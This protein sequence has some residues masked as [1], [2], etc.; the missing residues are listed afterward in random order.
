MKGIPGA[1]HVS[2]N[3][4]DKQYNNDVGGNYGGIYKIASQV[5]CFLVDIKLFTQRNIRMTM[6]LRCVVYRHK[7]CLTAVYGRFTHILWYEKS[8]QIPKR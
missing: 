5:F 3:S 8:L 2:L 6:M 7:Y 1:C 4:N